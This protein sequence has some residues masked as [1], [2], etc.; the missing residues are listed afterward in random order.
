MDPEFIC[1]V[2]ASPQPHVLSLCP[3]PLAFSECHVPVLK[4]SKVCFCFLVLPLLLPWHQPVAFELQK[5]QEHC[6]VTL[7]HWL[8]PVADLER[9]GEKKRIY[10]M[11]LALLRLSEILFNLS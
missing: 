4:W 10:F 11:V 5:N 1:G 3:F 8:L 6:L 2:C 9:K 7:L